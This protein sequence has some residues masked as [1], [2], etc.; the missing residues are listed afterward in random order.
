[1]AEFE[2]IDKIE[3]PDYG[4][5]FCDFS[6]LV[7]QSDEESIRPRRVNVVELYEGDLLNESVL[8]DIKVGENSDYMDYSERR[9]EY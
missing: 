6:V 3:I 9:G 2:R 5:D 8:T 7:E 1:M 4:P